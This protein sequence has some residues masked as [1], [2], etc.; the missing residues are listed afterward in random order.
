M[1]YTIAF[2][3][4][5]TSR[6]YLSN[7]FEPTL[8]MIAQFIRY[9]I[10]TAIRRIDIHGMVLPFNGVGLSFNTQL[11]DGNILK[12]RLSKQQLFDKS[13]KNTRTVDSRYLYVST[14]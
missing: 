14:S 5:Y 10:S 1:P 3:L 12:G 7:I 2:G 6:K 8:F 4:A 13:K 11:S 9:C